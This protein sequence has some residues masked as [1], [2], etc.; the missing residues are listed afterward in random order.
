MRAWVLLAAAMLIPIGLATTAFWH[1][2]DWASTGYVDSASAEVTLVVARPV[3]ARQ[4]P[5]TLVPAR[6]TAA[7]GQAATP[8]ASPTTADTPAPLA[9]PTDG[10]VPSATPTAATLALAAS[11]DVSSNQLEQA[12]TQADA[13]TTLAAPTNP[14]PTGVVPTITN[15]APGPVLGEAGAP[16]DRQRATARIKPPGSAEHAPP[17]QAKN[18][19]NAKHRD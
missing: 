3:S 15:R 10:V 14:T 16:A 4:V 9:M 19:T 12:R 7:P 13:S 5:P 2:A 18:K 8:S 17:G 1:A 6:G 11:G